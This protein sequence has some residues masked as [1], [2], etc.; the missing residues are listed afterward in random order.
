MW[1][2][3]KIKLS[4]V[5]KSDIYVCDVSI[6]VDTQY[7]KNIYEIISW[8]KHR[9]WDQDGRG[10]RH[11]IQLLPRTHK[12]KFTCRTVHTEHLLNPGRKP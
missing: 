3:Y 6:Q 4:C 12:K 7:I 9:R 11:G 10:V 1:G 5:T 2:Y 8:K